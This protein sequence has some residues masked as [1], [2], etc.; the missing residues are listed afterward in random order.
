MKGGAANGARLMMGH[1]EVVAPDLR[2][3]LRDPSVGAAARQETERFLQN[4]DQLLQW[5]L[6]HVHGEARPGRTPDLL[7]LKRGL[8]LFQRDVASLYV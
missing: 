5:F 8:D 3:A 1:L 7:T 6:E 4:A 2:Q